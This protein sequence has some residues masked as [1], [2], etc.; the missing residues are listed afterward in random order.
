MRSGVVIDLGT[1][2]TLVYTSK[3]GL[4]IDEPSVVAVETAGA[5]QRLRGV[6]R[7]ADALYGRAPEGVDIIKPLR[8]GVVSD[9]DACSLMLGGFLRRIF[10][11][12][13]LGR[14]GALVCVPGGA[15]E[16]ERTALVEAAE[17]GTRH[18]QIRL[19][20]EVAAAA[21]GTGA[22]QR[23]GE[24]VLVLDIGGGTTEIG[25]VV[26][27]GKVRSRS[28]RIAGNEMD[29]AIVRAVRDKHGLTI[30]ER[31]AERLKVA[32]GLSATGDAVTVT[33]VDCGRWGWLR[34]ADVEPRL[35]ADALER[36]LNAI[37][38]ALTDLL[39]DIP[40]DLAEEILFGGVHLAGGGASLLGLSDWISAR[41]CCHADIVNDPLRCVIRGM[42]VMLEPGAPAHWAAA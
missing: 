7:V 41:T 20:D 42:A 8:D 28:L 5:K 36:P 35:V 34:V 4:V 10:S 1:V 2:N 27:G 19:V 22:D 29:A 16:V 3:A 6:G 37:V 33:G 12:H 26:N 24:A 32:V 30:S 15:T 39:A 14:P 9:L 25:V 40:S 38:R 21:L 13:R 17:A 11:R 18:F 31:T 23:G